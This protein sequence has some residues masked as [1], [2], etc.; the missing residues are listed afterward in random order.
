MSILLANTDH[1]I[2][3]KSRHLG[4]PDDKVLELEAMAQ[5]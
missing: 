5:I 3:V 2:I 1:H 4:Q